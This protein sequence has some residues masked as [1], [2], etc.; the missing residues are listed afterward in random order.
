MSW[1]ILA[2]LYFASGIST[3]CYLEY[4]YHHIYMD[5]WWGRLFICLVVGPIALWIDRIARPRHVQLRQ[6][7]DDYFA[8]RLE[9]ARQSGERHRRLEYARRH[10]HKSLVHNWKKEGF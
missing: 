8:R 1:Q 4:R 3:F 6:Q 10:F 2:S 7:E 9:E 5:D